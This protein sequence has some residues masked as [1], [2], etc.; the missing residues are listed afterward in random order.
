MLLN[1]SGKIDPQTIEVL[2]IIS[3]EAAALK[4]P[5]FVIGAFARDLIL[6][7]YHKIKPTRKTIDLDLG[8][9]VA[10]W[11][12][13]DKLINRLSR[14]SK[15]S[16]DPERNSQRI[17]LGEFPVDIVPFGDVSDDQQNIFWPPDKA[18]KMSVAGFQE[19]YESSISVKLSEN[20]ELVIKIPTLPGL[21]ILKIISWNEKYPER[22]KDALDLLFIMKNYQDTGIDDRLYQ[23]ESMLKEEA[24]DFQNASIRLLGK[25]MAMLVTGDT[26][27]IVKDILENET[28]SDNENRLANSMIATKF[29]YD[30][31]LESIMQK[32]SKLNQG[33]NDKKA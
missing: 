5:F 18:V 10:V 32:L 1:L 20:P 9:K 29:D 14:E 33:F 22:N 16:P 23:E 25:D 26:Y 7:Y 19:V 28:R 15:F 8:I 30:K 2:S 6:E 21:A 31:Q 3:H 13:F 12:D 24:F 4:I 17:Y 11:E 27:R